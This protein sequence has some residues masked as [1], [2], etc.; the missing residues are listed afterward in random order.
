MTHYGNWHLN[1]HVER[2]E[3][4]KTQD[5][6]PFLKVVKLVGGERREYRFPLHDYELARDEIIAALSVGEEA[7]YDWGAIEYLV[8]TIGPMVSGP[9]RPGLYEDCFVLPNGQVLFALAN[10]PGLPVFLP[11]VDGSRSG[12][13]VHEGSYEEWAGIADLAH[14]N[15]LLTMAMA[16]AFTGPVAALLGIDAPHI[17]LVGS[18]SPFLF[19][20]ED[21]VAS[22][23]R[24]SRVEDAGYAQ[25]WSQPQN[26]LYRIAAERAH[27]IMVIDDAAREKPD[28]EADKQ[29]EDTERDSHL[30]NQQ[31]KTTV[32]LGRA[33]PIFSVSTDIAAA[34]AR[35]CGAVRGGLSDRL[36]HI[37]L[38]DGR[39]WIENLHD[40]PN[41][42]SFL[43]EL[44]GRVR[45]QGG[46]IAALFIEI[47]YDV[48]PN[49]HSFVPDLHRYRDDYLRMARERFAEMGDHTARHEA[50]ATI[51]AAGAGL[52]VSFYDDLLELSDLTESVLVCEAA[53]RKTANEGF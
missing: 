22:I 39:S 8:E 44:N 31:G 25:S 23:W 35:C 29:S 34:R 43:L 14:G 28:V 30:L 52:L 26:V 50:F 9:T 49:V 10:H 3:F 1:A 42:S 46:F 11:S 13:T 27:T 32:G 4:S 24:R 7:W 15:P 20:L 12:L 41:E 45:A 36:I 40:H 19:A 5:G 37:A 16:F 53:A 33:T 6:E 38:E 21:V 48:L 18:C 2:I 47:L 51:F 17:Q